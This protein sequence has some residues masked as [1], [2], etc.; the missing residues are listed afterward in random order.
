MSTALENL[1][2]GT[3]DKDGVKFNYQE[4]AD[5]S[6]TISNSSNPDLNGTWIEDPNGSLELDGSHWS[7]K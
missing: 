1:E 2:S 7:R 4:N 3:Y 5:G 6:W